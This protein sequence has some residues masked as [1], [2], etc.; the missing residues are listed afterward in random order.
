MKILVVNLS[1]L[2]KTAHILMGRIFLSTV[3]WCALAT[4]SAQ[5]QYSIDWFSIDGGGGTSSGGDYTVTGTIG[6]ADAGAEMTGGD[7]SLTGGFM[8]IVT[9]IQTPGA[10][11]LTVIRDGADVVVSWPSP[12][13]DWQLEQKGALSLPSWSAPVETISDDTTTKSIRVAAPVGSRFYRLQK[14]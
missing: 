6:Q 11:E 7:Y 14:P 4:M 8:S 5:A 1:D 13:T 2:K 3:L 10:P 9:A 12:S